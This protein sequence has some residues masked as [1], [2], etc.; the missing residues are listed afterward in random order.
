MPDIPSSQTPG[1]MRR[2]VALIVTVVLTVTLVGFLSGIREP[3]PLERPAE[4]EAPAPRQHDTPEAV[5]YAD[6]HKGLIQPNRARSDLATLIAARPGLFDP[7]VR[8]DEM[9][10]LAL[11]DRARWRAFDGAPPTIPHPVDFMQTNNCVACH[12]MGVRIGD[13]LATRISHPYMTNCTQCHVE[14]TRPEL[15][16]AT[17][18]SIESTFIGMARSGPGDRAWPGAP[19]TV[20]HTTWMRQDCASCHGLVARPGLRTT[21]P[22]L[23]NCT[24]CHTPSA[25]LDQASFPLGTNGTSR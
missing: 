24:Q 1:I 19:P 23:S 8:T 7:V 21:H 25:A 10:M 2:N 12:S 11:E 20:P 18:P 6:L 22:W 9:K 5:H 16:S 15:T 14:S 3:A 4:V 13:Q 17:S